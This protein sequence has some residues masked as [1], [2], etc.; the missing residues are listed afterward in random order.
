MALSSAMNIDCPDCKK[1]NGLCYKARIVSV[2]VFLL[3]MAAAFL[4]THQFVGMR[5]VGKVGVFIIASPFC[6]YASA[7]A[8]YQFPF[9]I[10]R[11]D[12]FI[13]F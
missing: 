5:E 1:H 12:P 11:R 4:L 13:K 8:G 10:K 3:T 2:L 7:I 9:L 6:M